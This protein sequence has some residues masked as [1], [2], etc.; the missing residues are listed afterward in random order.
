MITSFNCPPAKKD[1]VFW[2]E[3]GDQMI[4]CPL[5]L[6][7]NKNFLI[8]SKHNASYKEPKLADD[9]ESISTVDLTSFKYKIQRGLLE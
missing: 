6:A 5:G 4:N 3:F 8:V 9:I 2:A 7:D 1:D